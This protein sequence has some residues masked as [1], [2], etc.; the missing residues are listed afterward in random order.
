MNAR[1]PDR[2]PLVLRLLHWLLA[3]L[4]V[5]QL[6]LG[7]AAEH[8]L[9]R[10]QGN[11]VLQVHF[12]LGLL[13]LCLTTLRLCLRLLLPTPCRSDETSGWTRRVRLCVHVSLY[14]LAFALPISGYVIWIW[15]N[16]DR[17][18]LAGI[19][20]P[21][22]FV[23][24]ADETGRAIAWYVHVYGAWVLVVQASLHGTAALY[25]QWRHRDDFIARRMGLWNTRKTRAS[26]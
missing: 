19:E 6:L 25:H 8:W 1:S 5:A 17:N 13:I 7:F 12:K 4:L 21:A 2:Y 15:M 9:S 22:L 26:T 10:E 23:P 14:A 20:L 11:A 16:A 18:L 3:A 24:P